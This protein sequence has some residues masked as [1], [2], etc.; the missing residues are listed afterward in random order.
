MSSAAQFGDDSSSGS[1]GG[2]AVETERVEG[3]ATSEEAA[4][5]PSSPFSAAVFADPEQLLRRA[6]FKKMRVYQTTGW[7]HDTAEVGYSPFANFP[8]ADVEA[9]VARAVTSDRHADAAVGAMVGMAIADAI[10]APLEFLE[11]V[12][13]PLELDGSGEAHGFNAASMEYTNENNRFK[14]ERGQWTDDAAMGL[15]MADS[16]LAN[17]KFNGSDMRVRFHNWWFHGQSLFSLEFDQAP[18]GLYQSDGQDAGNGSLMR[19]A[20]VPVF[21]WRDTQ[22]AVKY[23]A[24]SSYTTHPGPLAAYACKVLSYLVAKAIQNPPDLS[25]TT[26]KAWIDEHVA[27][28]IVDV[29]DAAPQHPCA[30]TGV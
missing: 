27:S 6:N 24:L 28:F 17:R 15:C 14:L 13:A 22:Q 10:G 4:A 19:L 11:V 1:G 3:G 30:G 21:Y 16:L 26:A 5:S 29:L 18:D 7:H 25:V 20:P 8:T 2:P 9:H 12:D 23:A